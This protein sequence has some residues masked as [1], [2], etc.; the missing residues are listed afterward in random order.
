MMRFEL[1][2]NCST[3]FWKQ[4]TLPILKN[5]HVRHKYQ[6][7]ACGNKFGTACLS[8][9]CCCDRAVTWWI[10][11]I[12]YCITIKMKPVYL[13]YSTV[14]CKIKNYFLSKYN[15]HLLTRCTVINYMISRF[16]KY[17]HFF[18]KEHI[19]LWKHFLFPLHVLLST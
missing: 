13:N 18:Y 11:A 1:L 5:V 15:N 2:C 7:I 10:K 9:L 17:K 16:S 14:L 3:L 12:I 8:I 6:Q 19:L 4:H